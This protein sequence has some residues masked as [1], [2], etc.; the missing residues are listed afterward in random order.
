MVMLIFYAFLSESFAQMVGVYNLVNFNEKF[1]CTLCFHKSGKY[2][3]TLDESY[4]DDILE[5]TL[6]SVGKYF[7]NGSKVI[8]KDNICKFEIECIKIDSKTL[9]VSKSFGCMQSLKFV[10]LRDKEDDPIDIEEDKIISKVEARNKLKKINQRVLVG[11]YKDDNSLSLI[12]AKSSYKLHYKGLFLSMGSVVQRGN[13]L[14]LADKCLNKVFNVII[15]K[16]YLVSNLLPSDFK[17][18][19]LRRKK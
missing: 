17:G 14:E 4:S 19:V 7:E 3:I 15:E 18:V 11:E 1:A 2:D 10:L 9:F 5:S 8:L 13:K 6:L 12:I 16:E